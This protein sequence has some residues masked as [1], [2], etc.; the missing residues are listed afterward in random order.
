MKQIVVI[1]GKGGTGKTITT[2]SFGTL[3]KNKILCDCDVDA[4]DLYLLL[5]PTILETHG[6]KGGQK[7]TID[8][9]LCTECG[10]CRNVC[11]FDAIPHTF[12]VDPTSCEGCGIC[13]YVCPVDAIKMI[14]NISGEWF[15][16]ETKYGPMI[17]AKLGVAEEN[18]GKLV[19]IIREVS[20]RLALEKKADY[21]II[22]GPPGI[23]CPVIA[24]LTGVD[25]ALIVT[26]P[27]LSGIHDLER[28]A[29]VAKHFGIKTNCVINKYDINYENS[30][31]IE[32]WCK[33]ENISVIGKIP[34]DKKI[35]E[36][37]VN[38]IPAV[39]YAESPATIEIRKIWEKL[40]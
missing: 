21:V 3:A 1:S 31:A 8:S 36:A 6:F 19:S 12:V 5:H 33:G 18:S 37:L 30:Q 34:F 16:S 4:A 11:R 10:E 26:E 14:D 23:G 28:V 20:K 38:G 24:A 9:S 2:A 7:A 39:E 17:H 29:G 40:T 13:P 22:D 27:S 32:K 15:V 35:V 25:L